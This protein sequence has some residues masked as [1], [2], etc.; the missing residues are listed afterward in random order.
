MRTFTALAA[1]TALAWSSTATLTEDVQTLLETQKTVLQQTQELTK[2][3]ANSCPVEGVQREPSSDLST[4]RLTEASATNIS[5][6]TGVETRLQGRTLILGVTNDF[7]EPL[8]RVFIN[9]FEATCGCTLKKVEYPCKIS[10]GAGGGCP[11]EDSAEDWPG[12][13]NDFLCAYLGDQSLSTALYGNTTETYLE[14]LN[15]TKPDIT[16]GKVGPDISNKE[17]RFQCGVRFSTPGL[18]VSVNLFGN[19]DTAAYTSLDSEKLFH[20]FSPKLWAWL[21]VCSFAFAVSLF[22]VEKFD[23]PMDEGQKKK[24]K[25]DGEEKAENEF[26]PKRLAPILTRSR[27]IEHYRPTL[28]LKCF[29]VVW[30]LH[31]YI[32][33]LVWF[34]TGEEKPGLVFYIWVTLWLVLTSVFLLLRIFI[35]LTCSDGDFKRGIIM[36]RATEVLLLLGFIALSI[37]VYSPQYDIIPE[38]S[39]RDWEVWCWVCFSALALLTAGKA[40]VHVKGV[41]VDG[42]CTMVATLPP[43]GERLLNSSSWLLDTLIGNCPPFPFLRLPTRILSAL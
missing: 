25:G 4:R 13:W 27:E 31:W 30:F 39:K 42:K 10:D 9:K 3:L 26:K 37:I 40:V 38:N 17:A 43:G 6:T 18:A 16:M 5:S 7:D 8:M 22:F 24:E 21:V 2:K 15:M 28:K 33:A 41:G 12:G 11:D 20:I 36:L 34:L 29:C 23:W 32:V 14:R 1:V 35:D 19:M